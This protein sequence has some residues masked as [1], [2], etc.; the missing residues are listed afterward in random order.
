MTATFQLAD[1]ARRLAVPG[2]VAAAAALSATPGSAQD[3]KVEEIVGVTAVTDTLELIADNIACLAERVEALRAE[4]ATLANRLDVLEDERAAVAASYRNVNG[5]V[6]R[7]ERYFGPATFVL[8]GDRRGRSRS[9]ALD[10]DLVLAMC[11]DTDGCL[12]T[13]GL[14]GAVIDGE[15]VETMFATGPCTLH[16]DAADGTWSVSGLCFDDPLPPDA[17]A[18]ATPADAAQPETAPEG[19]PEAASG[20]AATPA[21]RWGRDGDA[22]PFGDV[23]TALVLLDFA[24]ACFLTEAQPETSRFG[25]S[26]DAP[27][28]ARDTDAD[29]FLVSAGAAW[30]PTGAF[31]GAYLPMRVTDPDFDCRLTLR[32]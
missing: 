2:L 22:R 23:Q 3:C 32:D 18:P 17:G 5:R 4:N 26:A 8:T 27:R 6:D 24:G 9:L 20:A 28:L 7:K 19:A 31:P 13:I 25:A 1:R 21:P 14:T 12:V 16:L 30:D 11:A 10:H 29:L 15:P